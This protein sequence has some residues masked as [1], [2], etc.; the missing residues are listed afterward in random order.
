MKRLM[1]FISLILASVSLVISGYFFLESRQVDE[2]ATGKE[3]VGSAETLAPEMAEMRAELN[4]L[5]SE[6]VRFRQQL[7]VTQQTEEEA[8]SDTEGAVASVR[9]KIA[10]LE[11]SMASLRSNYEG[12]SI[13]GAS[14]ER[15]AVFISDEGAIKAD[16]YFEAGKYAI[17][18]EGYL[19]Y[20]REN[21]EPKDSK[22][23][24]ERARSAY[25]RAGYSDM[26]IWVQEEKMRLF[27]ENRNHDLSTLAEM[28]KDAGR[29]DDAIGHISEAA[30]AATTAQSRLWSR[31]YWAWYNQ[32]RDGDEAGLNAYREVKQEIEDSGVSNEKLNER[33]DEKIDEINAAIRAESR[34]PD[35]GTV[36][37]LSSNG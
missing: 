20:Y 3:D 36:K 31:M 7:G 30:D 2:I 22:G 25:Q 19:T 6:V 27:P 33:V 5:A 14:E 4:T 16:E 23:V 18:A 21:T 32:L 28:E 12:M 34:R 1:P 35:T 29:Y 24:L 9:D 15:M 17:A 26:A 11:R 8:N 37:T 10:D 13:E